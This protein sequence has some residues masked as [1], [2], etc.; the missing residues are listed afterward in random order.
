MIR[1]SI[2]I[3][4]FTIERYNQSKEVIHEIVV[5]KNVTKSIIETLS[6][7]SEKNVPKGKKNNLRVIITII[8]SPK[9]TFLGVSFPFWQVFLTQ[10]G[11][12]TT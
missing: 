11:C 1:I 3:Y 6:K 10:I 4:T 2:Y 7:Y 12:A 9:M 5:K 8:L